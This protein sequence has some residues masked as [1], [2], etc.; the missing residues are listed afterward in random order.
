[1]GFVASTAK[2]QRQ[3]FV[4]RDLIERTLRQGDIVDA[5]GSA[6]ALLLEAMGRPFTQQML[7]LHLEQMEAE[8]LIERE[9]ADRK[10]RAIRWHASAKGGRPPG[11]RVK[12]YPPSGTG[13]WY[14]IVYR[15]AEGRRRERKVATAEAAE[16]LA[17]TL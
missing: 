16:A 13:R 7:L 3:R 4:A 6:T 5:Y 15:D 8:G 2:L 9:L 17:A 10:C 12:V 1:M 14:R 11:P